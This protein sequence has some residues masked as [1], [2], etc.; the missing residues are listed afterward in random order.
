M[1]ILR[2]E[3]RSGIPELDNAPGVLT[4]HYF[5]TALQAYRT[6][7]NDSRYHNLRVYQWRD[8]KEVDVTEIFEASTH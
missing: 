6:R 3:S 2:Y 4:L 5:D 8:G 1:Y 7:R